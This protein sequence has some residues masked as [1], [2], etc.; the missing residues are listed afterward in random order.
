MR[1][2][3]CLMRRCQENVFLRKIWMTMK[4]TMVLF[5]LAVTRLMASEAYSQI[6]KMTLQ[7]KDARV[8]E[9]LSEIEENSEFFFLYN[10]KLIDVDRKVSLDVNDQKIDEV[11]SDLFHGTNVLYCC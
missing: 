1:K 5:F 8:R 7:V 10:S 9:V 4:L 11:L 3:L 2:N 6:T